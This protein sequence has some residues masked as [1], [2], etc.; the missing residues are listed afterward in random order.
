MIVLVFQG[1][2]VSCL[3]ISQFCI[4]LGLGFSATF[5]PFIKEE[6]FGDDEDDIPSSSEIGIIGKSTTFIF[7]C[8][9]DEFLKF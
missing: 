2:A 7:K 4:G 5:V 9:N 8:A 6:G 3:N 1:I